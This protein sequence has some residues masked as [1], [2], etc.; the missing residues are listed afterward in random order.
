M[1]I[2]LRERILLPILGC[3]L[4]G[5][6]LSSLLTYNLSRQAVEQ[7]LNDQAAMTAQTLSRQVSTWIEELRN[8]VVRESKWSGYT[9]VLLDGGSNQEE[10]DEAARQ[11]ASMAQ[12]SLYTSS[13]TLADASGMVVASANRAQEGTLTIAERQYFREAM[14]G[15]TAVSEPLL[16]K[17]TAHPIIV[18]ATPVMADGRP[19][20]VLFA[21]VELTKL[22]SIIVDPIK[23]GHQGYAFAISPQGDFVAHPEHE[24]I[25]DSSL[26]NDDWMRAM[27]RE[28]NGRIAYSFQ[29]I[30]KTVT[31]T[32][33][34]Q[35]GWIIG[36]GASH[37]DIFASID[38]IRQTSM[39]V[40]AAVALVAAGLIFL[41]VRSILKA[42][43]Q[44][45]SF[46]TEVA[47]GNLNGSLELARNDELG[48]LAAALMT[49]VG[50]LKE[51]I[52]A[53]ETCALE[54]QQESHKAKE[55]T[56]EAEQARKDA[57]LARREG[58]LHAAS[59][60]EAIVFRV[61][62]SVGTL[63]GHIAESRE[64][65]DN[66]RERTTE[67]AA[68]I[69][70]MNATVMEV[71]RSASQAADHTEHA[72]LKATEGSA[73][74]R[75]VVAAIT[76]VSTKSS[77]LKDNLA[78]LGTKAKGI[79]SVMGVI[80]DIADQTNLLALNAAIEAAR[81]GDAGRG[82]AVVADEVR[83]LAE[84][85]MVATKEVDEAI[86]A[87][88]SAAGDNIR[89]TEEAEVSV[90]TSTDLAGTAGAALGDIVEIV[91]ASADQVRAIATASEQQ[92]AASEQISRGAVEVNHIA[93]NTA[94]AMS[95]SAQ[96]VRELV[97]LADDMQR[98]ITELKAA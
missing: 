87:I 38:D 45:V 73:V 70:E 86:K 63:N 66:Q 53:S 18:V 83:K 46:A 97:V 77:L 23:I 44:T 78:N 36:V 7:A 93:A 14:L 68:A 8:S 76:D 6:G 62:G 42:I 32:E 39:G 47:Q 81:A 56:A 1:K 61:H 55:A 92:S 71:A 20:G 37:D 65:A 48:S 41:I 26:R 60:L 43:R 30:E 64:G 40:T 33:E 59:Q 85:T 9:R 79:G 11:L 31:F 24:L 72:R 58:M 94:E 35:T 15:S 67:S 27:L 98:L 90:R 74:V 3:I 88:Q 80:S 52:A 28:R 21:A 96:S 2:G 82:F 16:T 19:V 84:K 5:M 10:V 89:S 25:L 49:M 51:M 12:H 91:Q 75:Q 50:R 22:S 4:I 29:G 34:P 69:E 17:D 13:V 95:D 57:E 54:A